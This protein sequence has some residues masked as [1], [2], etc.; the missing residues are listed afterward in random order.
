MQSVSSRIWTRVAVS[1]SYD[2]NNYTTDTS[3]FRVFGYQ[4]E[5]RFIFTFVKTKD[6]VLYN[7]GMIF[8]YINHFSLI[9]FNH[10]VWLRAQVHSQLVQ[11]MLA[12]KGYD[13]HQCYNK[14]PD[15]KWGLECGWHHAWKRWS[16]EF[17][18]FEKEKLRL[19]HEG[20]ELSFLPLRRWLSFSGLDRQRWIEI[21]NT[22]RCAARQDGVSIVRIVPLSSCCYGLKSEINQ[23]FVP[24]TTEFAC[25]LHLYMLWLI[26]LR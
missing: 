10:S 16:W 25:V 13:N 17:E 8:F 11:F 9:I 4:S 14:P 3:D 23:P 1:I 7:Q 2:D 26:S 21:L 6:P 20:M 5:D 22:T 18:D 12:L 24:E 15:R 19:D